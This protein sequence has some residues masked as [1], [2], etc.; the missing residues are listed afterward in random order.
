MINP[1]ITEKKK[2]VPAILKL[3]EEE[4][5]KIFILAKWIQVFTR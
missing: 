3:K 2:S 1:A 4:I 5:V